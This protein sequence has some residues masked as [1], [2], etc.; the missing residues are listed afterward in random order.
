M[1]KN[2]FIFIYFISIIYS[3]AQSPKRHKDSIFKL[4]Y[5]SFIISNKGEYSKA[6]KQL[7][8]ALEYGKKNDNDSIIGEAYN[9]IG[10][11]FFS[12]GD[13]NNAEK[14]YMLSKEAL[15]R[16]NYK[17]YLIYH[18]NNIAN[19][20]FEKK[21]YV[22]AEKKYKQSRDLA[23]EL[24]D[25][26]KLLWPTFNIA[27]IKYKLK[28]YTNASF[29]LKETIRLYQPDTEQQLSI[30][31]DSYTYLADINAK[32]ENYVEALENLR[33]A[34]IIALKYCY[35]VGLISI[36]K[37]RTI[38]FDKLN[39]SENAK[40]SMANQI[41][42]LENNFE[43]QQSLLEEKNK[44]ERNLFER[45]SSLNLTK[46]L[47]KNQKQ[48]IQK[49]KYFALALLTLFFITISVVILLY[50]SNK[51]RL[52]LN[53]RLQRKNKE[54]LETKEKT[55]YASQ[56]KT[57]F[58]STISH[59]LRTPL[60]AVTGITDILIDQNPKKEQIQYLNAL[61]SSGEHLLA[62]IN[63][64][65]QINK[66]DANKIELNN[67]EFNIEEVIN[68][69]KSALSYLKK[70]N[71]NTIHIHIDDNI[72][73]KLKGDSVKLSQIIINL[74]GNALKFT[75]NGNIWLNVD[76]ID[77]E[78][79]NK[80]V[81]ILKIHIK[82]DGIGISKQMQTR[83][84][85]DFY[86]ESVQLNRNYEGAGLGLA[87]VKRLLDAMGSKIYV[88]SE[89]NKGTSFSFNLSFK[90][91]KDYGRVM[92]NTNDNQNTSLKNKTI[93]VVDDNAINQMITKRILE[94]KNANVVVIDNGDD[95]ID[96]MKKHNF[97]V[98]LMD[99]HMPKMN[100]YEV[101]EIIRGFN[102]TTPIIALTAVD[103]NE[104]KEKMSSSGMNGV[105][106]K[107]FQ[108]EHFYVELFKFID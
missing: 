103:I 48:S 91:E 35:Y 108:L 78:S 44:L 100:G 76:C 30:I 36:E 40:K 20:Y 13:Y 58:F 69:L 106:S 10:G 32:K 70:E 77:C 83:I 85:E 9:C 5:E 2:A 92:K 3:S 39:Q 53:N 54:L 27:E 16:A 24:N 37:D 80:E 6:Y 8:F 45:E 71:N 105:I 87:I 57:N 75:I 101:T 7:S 107:P 64:I 14:N 56:L 46:E 4:I 38:L 52:K 88:E 59:E 60:Y 90:Y 82:D 12:I 99:I 17:S 22:N 15:V 97:D 102:K 98:V 81:V 79:E 34:E 42:Y 49:I 41:I 96:L 86:Q 51:N 72:P 65:L 55:E 50:R 19:L 94:T 18:Y 68:N 67:I 66:Y 93:L 21:D 11:I 89:P 63:N 28:D 29:Y 43:S 25:T 104:N 1:K 33:S 84:F 73:K 26:Y 47:N 61:K 95:A 23:L 74:V 31:I 62:L